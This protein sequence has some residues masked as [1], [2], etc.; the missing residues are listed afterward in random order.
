M[1]SFDDIIIGSG[2]GGVPLAVNLAEE[3]RKVAIFERDSWGGTCINAGCTPSKSLLAAAHAAQQAQTAERFGLSTQV[4]VQFPQVMD[5]VRAIIQDWSQ[6]VEDRLDKANLSLFEQEATFIDERTIT[7]GNRSFT[8]D[9]VIINTGKSSFIPAI[10]GLAKTPFITYESF[11]G[12]QDLPE[13]MLILG[14]GY[15]GIELGQALARLGSEV[16]ILDRNDRIIHRENIHVSKTIQKALRADGVQFH[17]QSDVKDVS[18]HGNT[19]SL[20][21][22][23]GN[24]LQGDALMVAVGRKPNTESLRPQKSQIE[25]DSKGH[26][27][28]DE[29]FQTSC[30]GVYA[31]GDVT[32]QPAFTHVSWEDHRRLSAIFQGQKR[33]QGDRPLAYAFFTD[34]QVGRVGMSLESAQEEGIDARSETLPLNH[35]ARALETDRT[36]GFYR[37]V[38]D[39]ETDRILGAT[40][41]G[42]EAAELIHIFI[43]HIYHQATWHDLAQA[44]HIHPAF[45]EALPT[46]ARKFKS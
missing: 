9:R 42:P 26:I 18:H 6:G 22:H 5:R 45:A 29:H 41:I 19:F 24:T 44:V 37:M 46:L 15:T 21:T 35:V 30:S 8:A 27:I 20:R 7:N 36:R 39:N 10:K 28:V 32:G 23:A 3:G 34:P 13:R 4:S 43:A 16:H 31:I 14:G 33:S 11:W 1:K 25:M 12:L 38:V 2:Q 17:F 40:L